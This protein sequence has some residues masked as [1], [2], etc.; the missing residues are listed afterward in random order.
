MVKAKHLFIIPG[1][2]SAFIY[3]SWWRLS[4]YLLFLVKAKHL[5]IIPGEVKHLFIIPGEG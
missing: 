4:T 3:Y 1:E 5:F 2:G